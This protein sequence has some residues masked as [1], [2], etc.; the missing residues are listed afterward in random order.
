M[1]D[2]LDARR[3]TKPRSLGSSDPSPGRCGEAVSYASRD[4]QACIFKTKICFFPSSLV[5]D[6]LCEGENIDMCRRAERVAIAL[7]GVSL[8]GLRVQI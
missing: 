3:G 1:E 5:I 2:V 8:A 4:S 6:H 7:D